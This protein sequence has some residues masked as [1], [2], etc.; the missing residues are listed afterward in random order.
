M[1]RSLKL[2]GLV[3]L[4]AVT[5]ALAAATAETAPARAPKL[6]FAE[7]MAKAE[8]D[9]A[10]TP[11]QKPLWDAYVA[12]RKA[13]Y[14]SHRTQPALDLPS[15]LE[16]QQK[17]F[18]DEAKVLEPLWASLTVSQRQ[19]ADQDLMPHRRGKRAVTPAADTATQPQ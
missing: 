5:P 7:K 15:W 3:A 4:L 6:S 16:Q 10:L 1:S 18:A 14:A 2:W 12:E 19:I 11:D 17:Q 8:A 13:D 9:L